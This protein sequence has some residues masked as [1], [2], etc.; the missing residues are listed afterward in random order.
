MMRRYFLLLF[1]IPLLTSC[2]TSYPAADMTVSELREKYPN[3]ENVV[4]YKIKNGNIAVGMTQWMVIDAW[5]KPNDINT[6]T[7]EYGSSEQWV[8]RTGSYDAKYVYFE[9]GKVE[10][11]QH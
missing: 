4:L 2:M 11:I 9:D 1:I 6:T 5:G 3:A 10:T 7:T 8:Y